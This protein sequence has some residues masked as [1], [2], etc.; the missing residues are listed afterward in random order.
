LDVEP[1]SLSSFAAL[2]FVAGFSFDSSFGWAA[3]RVERLPPV[4]ACVARGAI[5]DQEV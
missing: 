3:I 2:F 5:V 4:G 1:S